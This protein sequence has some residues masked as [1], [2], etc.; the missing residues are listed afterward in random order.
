MQTFTYINTYVCTHVY[1]PYE[2]SHIEIHYTLTDKDHWL[3]DIY[4]RTCLLTY[5]L[6]YIHTICRSTLDCAQR[7]FTN[8]GITSFYRGLA[9]PFFAQTLCQVS[10]T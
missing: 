2:C 7:M 5:L 10:T 1:V 8:E 9:A 4:V 3:F 6:T